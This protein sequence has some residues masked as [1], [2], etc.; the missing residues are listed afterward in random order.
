MNVFVPTINK[1]TSWE[2]ELKEVLIMS[3]GG[4][5][6][7]YL[8]LYELGCTVLGLWKLSP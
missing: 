7:L 1:Q 5:S 6:Y 8:S 4:L 3:R 2:R